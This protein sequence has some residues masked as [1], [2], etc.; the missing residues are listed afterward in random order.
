MDSKTLYLHSHCQAVRAL[1]LLLKKY[2]SN[3]TVDAKFGPRTEHAVR[4]AQRKLAIFP[5]D[6]IAGPHTLD[7]LA[8]AAKAAGPTNPLPRPASPSPHSP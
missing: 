1:Q 8:K 4:T 5:A 2:E 7:A 3:L 6:G